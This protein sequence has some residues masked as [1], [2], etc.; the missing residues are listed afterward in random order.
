MDIT[1]NMMQTYSSLK[2]N[3]YANVCKIVCLYVHKHLTPKFSVT[4]NNS[5]KCGSDLI[6]GENIN[7]L[8]RHIYLNKQTYTNDQQIPVAARSKA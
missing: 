8:K 4:N 2:F 7:T 5:C 6:L 1:A 3:R